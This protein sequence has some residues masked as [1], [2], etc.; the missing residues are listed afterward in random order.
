MAKLHFDPN[1]TTTNIGNI[2]F[3]GGT[4]FYVLILQQFFFGQS[5]DSKK[6]PGRFLTESD[7]ISTLPLSLRTL[8]YSKIAVLILF[9]S[10]P[11][12]VNCSDKISNSTLEIY[13]DKKTSNLIEQIHTQIPNSTIN[14]KNNPRVFIPDG[15][16]LLIQIDFIYPLFLLLSALM[17]FYFL[18]KHPS[19]NLRLTTAMMIGFLPLIFQSFGVYL[20]NQN[21]LYTSFFIWFYQWHYW[22]LGGLV[23]SLLAFVL[24]LGEK[25]EAR[26]EF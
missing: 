23:L 13:G 1:T 20:E 8:F 11:F 3:S 10:L 26:E 17:I 5:K 22:V 24:F 21:S 14:Y 2:V 18:R 6:S 7:L 25:A 12:F 9:L 16:I 15:S 19:G 4:V